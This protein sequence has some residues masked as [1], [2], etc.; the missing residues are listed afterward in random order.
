MRQAPSRPAWS[1]T[2]ISNSPA[3]YSA[4][5]P[6]IEKSIPLFRS[7]CLQQTGHEFITLPFAD[8]SAWL[9]QIE[10][11][12][13]ALASFFGLVIDHTMQGFYGSPQYGGNRAAASWKMLTIEDVME[14]HQH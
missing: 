4:S 6:C 11:G 9:R 14:G 13:S 2:S 3:P 10:R 12:P 1:T 8:Q 7:A 5:S